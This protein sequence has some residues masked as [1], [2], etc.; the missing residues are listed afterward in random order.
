MYVIYYKRAI[1][2]NWWLNKTARFF[3]FFTRPLCYEKFFFFFCFNVTIMIIVIIS[4]ISLY[5]FVSP[6]FRFVSPVPQTPREASLLPVRV[7]QL[8]IDFIV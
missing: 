2:S 4:E 5:R 7:Y 1:L 6:P 8:Q 3:F